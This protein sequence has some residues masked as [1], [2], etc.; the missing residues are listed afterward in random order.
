MFKFMNKDRF[1]TLCFLRSLHPGSELREKAMY[2]VSEF[3]SKLEKN[4]ERN[5]DGSIVKFGDFAN[6]NADNNNMPI[7]NDLNHWLSNVHVKTHEFA[8]SNSSS[9]SK[10]SP[11]SG[12][13]NNKPKSTFNKYQSGVESAA[14]ASGKELKI[15]CGPYC[16]E[17]LRSE[18]LVVIDKE[19]G[20]AKSYTATKF[21]C[22]LCSGTGDKKHGP[23]CFLGK[24]RKCHFFGHKNA[25]CVNQRSSQSGQSS[26]S[27]H[28]AE[29]Y[30][31]DYEPLLGSGG[32][33]SAF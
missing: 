10:Q 27:G 33:I 31:E 8:K 30:E 20:N 15:A 23:K 28:S 25:D 1:F 14:A 5:Y 29:E 32:Y 6:S 12:G 9:N 18:D 4:D 24:C 17:V 22:V 2:H 7:Y 16:R 3:M 21:A 11:P 26:Q 13:G 19:S